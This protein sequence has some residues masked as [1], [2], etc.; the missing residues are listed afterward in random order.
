MKKLLISCIVFVS[1]ITV[2]SQE[3]V[4][5]VDTINRQTAIYKQKQHLN[6]RGNL[7]NTRLIFEKEKVGRVAFLGGSITAMKGWHNQVMVY[8]TNRFPDTK[9]DFIEAGIGST[10]S[11]PGSFRMKKDVFKN[12]KVDLLF[13]EAAVNDDTNGFD[14]IAQIR[15]MEGEVRQALIYNPNMD[16]VMQHFIYDR[17]IPVLNAGKQPDVILNHEKVA[18]YYQIPSINQAQEIAERMKAGEFDWKQFGG[19]HP[20]PF[21]QR[22]Y[23]ATMEVLLDK[24]WSVPNPKTKLEPH[25]ISTK[26]LDNFSYF[27]GTLVD[28]R[29][30]KIKTGWLYE[31]PW[32]PKEPAGV[33]FKNVGMLEALTPE[34]ELSF[35]FEGTAIGIYSVCG[36]NAGIVEYSIDGGDFKKLDLFTK[37]S[38]GLYIPWLHI[39]AGDL[40]NKKHTLIMKMSE[41]KN[42]DSKNTACQIYYFAVNGTK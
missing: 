22:F 3:N 32:T 24:M 33:R 40:K 16:I 23:A 11:T 1:F 31:N 42:K 13:V 37:W 6:S 28:P 25:I 7:N 19:T 12:G 39:F 5:V 36:P 38:K 18:E 41:D 15:G 14:S 8:L 20:L 26:P 34:S 17:F 27:N 4:D 35:K 2:F 9:F 30:A 29:E 21:G 10:G